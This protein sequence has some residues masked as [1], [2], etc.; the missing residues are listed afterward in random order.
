FPVFVAMPW[1]LRAATLQSY[2]SI[3][4]ALTATRAVGYIGIAWGVVVMALWP[5]AGIIQM[6]GLAIVLI[7]AGRG[8][9]ESRLAVVVL[10]S[11][12]LLTLA[13]FLLMWLGV[14]Y[15]VTLPA[16]IVMHVGGVVWLI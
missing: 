7:A 6:G 16:G 11:G 15:F 5:P 8:V 3:E 9:N 4:D 13:S 14:A 2:T 10:V 12:L 1:L